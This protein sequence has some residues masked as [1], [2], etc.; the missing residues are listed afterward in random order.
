MVAFEKRGLAVNTTADGV[1]VSILD[2]SLGFGIHYQSFTTAEPYNGSMALP[3]HL[4]VASTDGS[5]T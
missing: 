2:E 4:L 5:S 3:R 1:R